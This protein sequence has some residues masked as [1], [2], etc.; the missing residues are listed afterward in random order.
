MLYEGLPERGTAS[1]SV[2][3]SHI[4]QLRWSLP[5]APDPKVTLWDRVC[6]SFF[7]CAEAGPDRQRYQ[8]DHSP[9]SHPKIRTRGATLSA[10][11]PLTVHLIR[12]GRSAIPEGRAPWRYSLLADRQLAFS[13][14]DVE[15]FPEKTQFTNLR[16]DIL[17]HYRLHTSSP[18][19]EQNFFW[20]AFVTRLLTPRSRKSG[21]GLLLGCTSGFDRGP[22]EKTYFFDK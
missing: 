17:W 11:C 12:S 5:N 9:H 20:P 6:A 18:G 4:I 13:P 22:F 7:R 15:K 1:G 8:I 19:Q 14:L 10:G 16:G 21:Y 2:A 3:R